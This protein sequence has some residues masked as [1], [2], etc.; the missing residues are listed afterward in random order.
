MQAGR[1]KDHSL[2]ESTKWGKYLL[3][4]QNQELSVFTT[5]L[6]T[7]TG[8]FIFG[9]DLNVTPNTEIIHRLNHYAEDTFLEKHMFGAFTFKLSFPT[10]RLDYLFHSKDVIP[11]KSEV[12]KLKTV[13]SDHFPISAEFLIPKSFDQIVK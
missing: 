2:R 10:M 9:G 5:Y 8:P 6:Q 3:I 13:L 1:P 7:L 11:K 4:S 12:V